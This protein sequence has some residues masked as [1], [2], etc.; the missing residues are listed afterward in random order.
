MPCL[1]LCTFLLVA[2]LSLSALDGFQAAPSRY[3]ALSRSQGA[4]P[5]E[6]GSWLVPAVMKRTFM[7]LSAA[8]PEEDLLKAKSIHVMKRRCNTATCVTQ[9]LADF[10]SRSNS[11]LGAFYL[12]T[13]VGSNTYGKRDAVGLYSRELYS[14]LQR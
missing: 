1:K 8:L 11:N 13:N 10:L 5:P 7:G 9:R 12:P 14:Y 6:F 4:V 2:T 3:P